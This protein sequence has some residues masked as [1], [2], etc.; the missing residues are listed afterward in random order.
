MPERKAYNIVKKYQFFL[1]LQ[2]MFCTHTQ[3]F[4]TYSQF[5]PFSHGL[6][7]CNQEIFS[8]WL[9][10]SEDCG[11]GYA[12]GQSHCGQIHLADLAGCVH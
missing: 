8:C 2:L 7:L 10:H 11:P 1:D 3:F 12:C 6:A 4:F 5:L 9:S